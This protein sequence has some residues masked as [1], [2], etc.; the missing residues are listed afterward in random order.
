VWLISYS[1][2]SAVYKDYLILIGGV[3]LSCLLPP[4]EVVHIVTGHSQKLE[5]PVSSVYSLF[6][7]DFTDSSIG[8]SGGWGSLGLHAQC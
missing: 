8:S 7:M 4:V 3:S 6:L 2:T 5:L 1:H